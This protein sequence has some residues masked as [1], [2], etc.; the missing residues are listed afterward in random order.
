MADLLPEKLQRGEI[1]F[2]DHFL[3]ALPGGNYRIQVEQLVDRSAIA[4]EEDEP[5]ET[6]LSQR[7]FE[8]VAP[9]FL[10]GAGDVHAVYPPGNSE[11]SFATH[12]PHIVLRKRTLPWERTVTQPPTP[13]LALLLCDEDDG[14]GPRTLRP[15]TEMM[16]AAPE[17]VVLPQLL[18]E[19]GDETVP[20]LFT[21]D[22]PEQS[23]R[24]L[25]PTEAELPLLCHVRQVGTEDKELLGQTHDGWFSLVVANRLPKAGQ[26]NTMHLVSLEGW[27]EHLP[28]LTQRSSA[29][30]QLRE[31]TGVATATGDDRWTIAGQEL[32]IAE[33][34][35]RIEATIRAGDAVRVRGDIW[36]DGA[37]VATNIDRFFDERRAFDFE[38][39]LET[40][41]ESQWRVSGATITIPRESDLTSGFSLR[42]IVRL[43]GRIQ[44]DGSWLATS[45]RLV[46]QNQFLRLVS[47]ASWSFK[48]RSGRGT[49]H[50][51]MQGV[52]RGLLT[53]PTSFTSEPP[54]DTG[55]PDAGQILREALEWG[56]VPLNYETRLAE[57]SVGWYRGPLQPVKT[58]RVPNEPFASAEAALIYD[59]RT[60]LFDTS[61]AAAWQVGRLLALADSHFAAEL[62]KWRQQ[63]HLLLDQI[64]EQ[65]QLGDRFANAGLFSQRDQLQ[66]AHQ[67]VISLHAELADLERAGA[68]AALILEF[69]QT[70]NRQRQEL[71]HLLAAFITALKEPTQRSTRVY[72][73]LLGEMLDS[74][75]AEEDAD[76]GLVPAPNDRAALIAGLA[77][78]TDADRQAIRALPP[79]LPRASHIRA[80]IQERS[81]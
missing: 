31:L 11:G 60:G 81:Q 24:F 44:A 1:Q 36:P 5:V 13:W 63:G 23:F 39:L 58:P 51:L 10:L 7:D 19:T 17:G 27:Q 79:G 43:Q 72:N 2:Y 16:G 69:R 57:K 52:D 20:Q 59:P 30:G 6:F 12:L 47:L 61:Y 29:L 3:P 55:A 21:V 70:L 54:A 65:L 80:L 73:Y 62:Q 64:L 56:Y 38:G 37:W 33:G 75:V 50:E 66:K 22:I 28:T 49:F 8:V 40:A 14:V 48:V 74:L 71:D 41:T 35:T 68:D 42:D 15:V 9:R 26:H 18:P 34:S 25:A 4:D 67:S 53:F 32:V 46:A 76:R 77:A 45:I 78:L